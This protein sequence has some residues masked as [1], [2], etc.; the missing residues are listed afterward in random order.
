MAYAPLYEFNFNSTNGKD[1]IV[2]INADG[3]VGSVI[4]RHVGGSPQLRLEQNGNIKG[5]SLEWPAECVNEDEYATLY[6]SNP[7]KYLVELEIEGAIRW[8]G[9]IT[10]ELYSS[11]WVDPPY[12][13]T[14]TATDGLGELKMHTYPALGRQTL[15]ALFAT[16]LI[17]T[18]MNLPVKAINTAYNDIVTPETLFANTTVN[19]DDMAGKSYY[20][21]LD[22]LLTAIH[23]TIQQSGNEWLIIR[24]TDITSETE[25]DEVS[26]T[27]GMTYPIVPFGSMKTNDVWP[28]GRLSMEIVPAKNSI[29]VSAE[30]HFI[31][32]ILEDPDMMEGE[33]SGNGM[34]FTTDG[35]FYAL[36]KG[37][38]IYQDFIPEFDE[39]NGYPD[40]FNWTIKYRQSGYG[41][42]VLRVAIEASG[43]S[44]ET[45]EEVTGSWI[46]LDSGGNG[47]WANGVVYMF[48]DVGSASRGNSSDCEE[49][50]IGIQIF[51]ELTSWMSRIDRIRFNL[52]S[53]TNTI[54]I[55]HSSVS[56][57]SLISGVNTRLI[58]SNDARGAAPDVEPSF[59]D[60][61][62]GN[63]G[64]WFITNA[65]Y[66]KQG[67]TFS[68]VETWASDIIP[69][70]PYGEWLAKDNALSVATPR[71]RLRG[72][73]NM[74]ADQILPAFFYS[75]GG[76]TYLCETYNLDLLND[77]AEVSLI[78]L[79][80]A[81]IEVQSVRQTG[82]G[83]DGSEVDSSVSVFPASFTLR[84]DDTT[85]RSYMAITAPAN[86]SWTVTGLP[87]WVL[88]SQEEQSGTGSGTSSFLVTANTGEARQ[89]V[90]TVAGIPVSIFQDESGGE[91]SLTFSVTPDGVTY[92]MTLDGEPATYTEGMMVESGVIVGITISKQGYSTITDS[93]AM[94]GADTVKYYNLSENIEATITPVGASIGQASQNVSYTISDASNHGWVLDF[95]GPDAYDRITGAGVTSGIATVSGASIQGTGN[96]IVYLTVPAN[97]NAHTRTIDNSPFYFQDSTTNTST[98]LYINQLGTQDS[99]VLVTGITLNKNTLSL[100][101]GT[102]EKLTAT[103]S[104]SNATNKNLTWR[105]SNTAK[106]QV[107]QDGTVHAISAGTASVIASATDG[108]GKS[109]SCTVTVTG[110]D[111][112]V[113][114]VTIDK[115]SL[116]V[117]VGLTGKLNATVLPTNATNKNVTWTSGSTSV[118]TVN[119]DGVVTGV[120]KGTVRIDVTTVD[121]GFTASSFVHV[122][123]N[124][125]MTAANA[126]AKSAATTA[127]T[128]LTT[129]NMQ[130]NTLTASCAAGW[131]T[132]LTVDTT[133]TPW[134]VR[135]TILTNVNTTARTATV[136]V[137][138]LD[139]EGETVTATFTLTQT[140]K[141]SSDVPVTSMT[142]IGDSTIQNSGNTSHY[143]IQFDPLTT[144]QNKVTWSLTG[145]SGAA[146][147]AN[148][149]DGSVDVVVGSGALGQTVTLTATNYYN[150]SV[151][152]TKT[153]TVNYVTPTSTTVTP[154]SVIVEATATTDNTPIVTA[155]GYDVQTLTASCSGF[156]TSASVSGERLVTVFSQ[157][158]GAVR[159]G[160]VALYRGTTQVAIVT[161]TQEA[162]STADYGINIEAINVRQDTDELDRPIIVAMFRVAYSNPNAYDDVLSSLSATLVGYNSSDTQ[163]L[164]K[165]WQLASKTVASLSTETEIYT[166]EWQATLPTV[167]H[168][169]L[170]VTC[171]TV[172]DT[173]T[174][175]GNDP[176]TT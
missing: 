142:I 63:H 176:I 173:Y 7:Y 166:E 5:M 14:L 56:V 174:S 118:A 18:G 1:V 4:S 80:A 115:S 48:V 135:M 82:Y 11:P 33:W 157:N 114:G 160:Q 96:A 143:E 144:T 131:V 154:S 98:S 35:G 15:E 151:V 104:P 2:R 109:A 158:T 129:V 67:G 170:T 163:V 78:S 54:Y 136:T 27:S 41:E 125:S 97:P 127:S 117:G 71:L 66:G 68:P 50:T 57:S 169:T 105:S 76:L 58:L 89:A 28:V 60:T 73:L 49:K 31:Q 70:L 134:R 119:G 95:D 172:T 12:D 121:G 156:I 62:V 113:T 23:A 39:I 164:T 45:G 133:G 9:F 17:A 42:A 132:G 65:V 32:S 77:E 86:L 85:T 92:S 79:P 102:S 149:A 24:E 139:L 150:S 87:A 124:G 21:V 91:H 29:K 88:M 145:G 72:R 137:S 69:A 141:T 167:D 47:Y 44:A 52:L 10:P 130:A 140:G 107:G 175:D 51:G 99:Q 101:T 53:N 8:R 37:M 3:Y 111:I 59:A 128:T 152:A 6:T 38:A 112:S 30:N 13:V 162:A 25:D 26:D 46:G 123:S 64:L 55:H 22:A 110:T 147:L 20:D 148:A 84:A 94:P 61:Y 81:A 165:T 116:T 155:S 168:Y 103:V 93:F 161:Y 108:S 83:E 122:T 19:L 120:H 100:A 106:V 159:Y 74:P 126:S 36:N 138:G 16:L 153:I 171:S 34:H 75:T 40:F 90:I 43:I 146:S